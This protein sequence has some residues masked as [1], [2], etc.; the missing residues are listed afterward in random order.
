[1]M[2]PIFKKKTRKIDFIIAGTQKGGTTALDYYLRKHPEIGMA[3]NKEA[4]FF[5]NENNFSK[6]TVNYSNYHNCFN[7]KDKKTVYGEATPI[8]MYWKT[9]CKRIWEYNPKIKL[10]FIL[11]NPIERAFSHWNMEYDRGTD[12]ETFSYAIK[13]ETLR[14]KEA[15]PL[16][17]RIYSY[18]DRGY[19]S[20]QIKRLK[21]F[22]NENQLMFIKYED[23]KTNQ[24][25]VLKEIFS[26]LEVSPDNY[27]FEYQTIHKRDKHTKMSIEEK[28]YLLNSFK[29][30]IYDVEKTLNWDCSDWLEN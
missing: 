20:K 16:Q 14:T 7:F 5:D 22:F 3:K 11:R 24:E 27:T 8:Y 15:Y 26:F 29:N 2:F 23:F 9:S 6:S 19:Y 12:K 1:M 4:H 25:S 21:A 28:K 18:K 30:E 10:I 17:H 13:N